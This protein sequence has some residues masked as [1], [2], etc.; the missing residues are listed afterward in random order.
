LE[1]END[2]KSLRVTLTDSNDVAKSFSISVSP[3]QAYLYILL[4]GKVFVVPAVNAGLSQLEGIVDLTTFL[5]SDG[6]D[7]EQALEAH[8]EKNIECE[9]DINEFCL[10]KVDDIIQ[11]FSSFGVSIDNPSAFPKGSNVRKVQVERSLV[12]ISTLGSNKV[13]IMN[14]IGKNLK[15]SQIQH[16]IKVFVGQQKSYV[17]N[18]RNLDKQLIRNFFS[19]NPSYALLNPY[20]SSVLSDRDNRILWVETVDVILCVKMDDETVREFQL[21][22]NEVKANL[23][24]YARTKSNGARYL[25]V[26]AVKLCTLRKSKKEAVYEV[27]WSRSFEI[28]LGNTR[29]QNPLVNTE[30]IRYSAGFVSVRLVRGEYEIKIPVTEH[31]LISEPKNE[32]AYVINL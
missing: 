21:K 23:A 17:S 13:G 4:S 18:R 20:R 7:Q 5:M 9:F 29:C 1:K 8:L 30:K 14:I 22:K 26:K 12:H 31:L 27:F 15:A 6:D 24:E 10:S 32:S 2:N 28:N 3:Q 19:P 16:L 11:G 25:D